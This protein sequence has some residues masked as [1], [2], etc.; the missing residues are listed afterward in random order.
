VAPLL[1]VRGVSVH[2][3]GLA[4]VKNV[5]FG[6]EPGE[7]LALIGPNGAGKT[8][9]FN[10][11]TGQLRPSAGS[12]YFNGVD[13]THASVFA[14]THLGMARS[15]QIT[16]LFP[17]QTVRVNALIALQGTKRGRY[18]MFRGLMADKEMQAAAQKLLE[19]AE[20]WDLREEV[21]SALAYG[22]QRKLEIALSLASDP[23]LLLLDEPSCGLTATE[24]ADITT[25]IRDLGAKITVLMIA[26]DMDLV[27]GVA[28]RVML[29]H[30][31]EIACEGTC[32]EI[33]K[34]QLVRDV[35]MGSRKTLG[36]GG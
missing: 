14:R 3:G 1:D 33:R 7:R 9:L 21:V 25:H 5:T 15:F 34:N 30:Y 31:G 35:Y 12:V 17:Y 29:L 8:T 10:V 2:F 19:R 24:S 20:L 22:Q 18:S 26:H 28:E 27:F 23:D 13:I 32:D 16:S 36:A 11:L 6:V 4:A